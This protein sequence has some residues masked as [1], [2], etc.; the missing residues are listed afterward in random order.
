M[1]TA[2]PSAN[3]ELSSLVALRVLTRR[4]LATRRELWFGLY[5]SEAGN[6]INML[7]ATVSLTHKQA[8]DIIMG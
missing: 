7:A 5:A 1:L 4:T 3:E 8:L 6:I 2:V